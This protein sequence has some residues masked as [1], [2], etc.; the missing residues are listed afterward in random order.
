MFILVSTNQ[1]FMQY[2]YCIGTK[3]ECQM[4]QLKHGIRTTSEILPF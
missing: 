2:A 3:K 4:Y 1:I